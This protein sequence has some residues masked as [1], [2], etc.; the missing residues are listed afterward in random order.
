MLG[1]DGTWITTGSE[2]PDHDTYWSQLIESKDPDVVIMLMGAWDL[3]SRDWGNGKVAPG[4]REFD[5][6][7]RTA[8]D[9]S[10][11]VLSAKGAE[12]VVLTTPCFAPAPGERA[13]PQHDPDRA[14][15]LAQIQRDAVES[16][17][18]G[19]PPAD[20]VLID[21]NA[22]TCDGGFTETRDGVAWRPDGS[23]FSVDGSRVAAAWFLQSLPPSARQRLGLDD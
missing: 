1:F 3:Y 6:R 23:H 4:D 18:E 8:L 2:C 16:F 15:R 11:K 12:V 7:Y 9:T 5:M 21:L 13:G 17:N 20:A 19:N 22:I 10:M 14:V